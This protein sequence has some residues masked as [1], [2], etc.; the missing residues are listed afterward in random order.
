MG[1]GSGY[2][3]ISHMLLSTIAFCNS[4]EKQVGLASAAL[5]GAGMEGSRKAS[6][7]LLRQ[8]QRTVSRSLN[9]KSGMESTAV[10]TRISNKNRDELEDRTLQSRR[11]SPLL[12]LDT[13]SLALVNCYQKSL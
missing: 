7:L 3:R 12:I 2:H 9:R 8:H 4:T 6:F 5:R 11:I 13:R 1:A 10:A